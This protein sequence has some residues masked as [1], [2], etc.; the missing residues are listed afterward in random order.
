MT[1]PMSVH[2]LRVTRSVPTLL[3]RFLLQVF[4]RLILRRSFVSIMRP[5][6]RHPTSV[7][8]ALLP[9]LLIGWAQRGAGHP[10]YQPLSPPLRNT[11]T[12][13]AV[14][15]VSQDAQIVEST[16]TVDES[17]VRLI[18]TSGSTQDNLKFCGLYADILQFYLNHIL[19]RYSSQ[20]AH[21]HRLKDDLRRIN[22]DLQADAAVS[23]PQSVTRHRNRV[24]AEEFIS[25]FETI[26]ERRFNKAV[27]EIDILYSQLQ[28]YCVH[29]KNP[30]R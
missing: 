3:T 26:G 13:R 16:E 1:S 30:Q 10:V 17:D 15:Q 19:P 27:A 6:S 20:S 28:F 14:H 2:F 29:T 25:K 21:V 24:F 11:E 22:D 23:L 7:V 9:L 8:L 18:P 5:S 4:E 12:Y